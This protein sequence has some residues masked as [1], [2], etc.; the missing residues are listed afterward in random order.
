MELSFKEHKKEVTAL[1]VSANDEEALSSSAD[2]SCVVW[3]LRRG[4]RTNAFF[5][6]T[7]FRGITYHPDESQIITV[8]SDRKIS[9]W[10]SS[11]CTAIRVMDGSTEEVRASSQRPSTRTLDVQSGDSEFLTLSLAFRPLFH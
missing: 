1:T 10:D 2:G 11:D 5:S 6:S 7:V 9:Y 4:V 8:G 3:N